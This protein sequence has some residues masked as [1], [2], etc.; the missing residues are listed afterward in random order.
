MKMMIIM[1]MVIKKN[2]AAIQNLISE[3]DYTKI[4]NLTSAMTVKNP[5]MTINETKKSERA[6]QF[7]CGKEIPPLREFLK[8][9]VD[10][11][12]CLTIWT[13]S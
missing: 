1:I 10:E 6:F 12:F 11:C 3:Q 4:R 5:T 9:A 7:D 13:G 8:S 2:S